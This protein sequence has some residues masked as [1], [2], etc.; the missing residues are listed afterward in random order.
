MLAQFWE[1]H[2]MAGFHLECPGQEGRRV[3]EV[4]SGPTHCGCVLQPVMRV[5][6]IPLIPWVVQ[7]CQGC[8]E[9]MRPKVIS[10]SSW[11]RNG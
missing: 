2:K 7:G 6:G 5:C 8:L 3:V 4:D 9:G 1:L 11:S 10:A